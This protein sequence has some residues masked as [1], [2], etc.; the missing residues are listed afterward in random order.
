[1]FL[2]RLSANRLAFLLPLFAVYHFIS[3][4]DILCY[5]REQTMALGHVWLRSIIY[6]PEP[7]MFLLSCVNLYMVS[8]ILE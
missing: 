4:V 2:A 8:G 5:S 7:H 6:A 3:L 1:L